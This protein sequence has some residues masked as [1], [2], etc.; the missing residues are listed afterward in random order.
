MPSRDRDLG[1]LGI[2]AETSSRCVPAASHFSAQP[3]SDSNIGGRLAARSSAQ[4]VNRN[5][6][7]RH[8]FDRA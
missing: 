5:A 3:S 1:R 6:I 2:K 8:F 4:A 7:A